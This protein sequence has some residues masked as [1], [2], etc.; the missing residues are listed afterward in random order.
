MTLPHEYA[1][2][3][4]MAAPRT[5]AAV[6]A[7]LPIS[8]VPNRFKRYLDQVY[9]AARTGVIQL[10]GQNVFVYRDVP[11]QL[12]EADVAFGVGVTT[13]FVAVGN[14]EPTF[15]PVGEVATTTHRG[16]YAELGAAHHAV[17]DWCRLH[18]R[19]LVGPRWEVYAHW[20]EDE[21]LLRTDVFYL[22]EPAGPG[23]G[24]C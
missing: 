17:I 1:V 6:H 24:D 12:A 15:L 19:R 11:D 20:T 5:I 8:A 23:Q 3:L 22:L 14:V 10:D 18:G 4:Q 21:T 2:S 7:R 9:A 13:P 16:N